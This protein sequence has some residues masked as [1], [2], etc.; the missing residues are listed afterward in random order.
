MKRPVFLEGVLVAGIASAAGAILFSIAGTLVAGGMA[1]RL[2]V[3]AVSLAYILYLL[4]R[5]QQRIGRI[6]CIAAWLVV[7]AG[8]WI[9]NPSLV[10]YIGAHIGLIWLCR[11]LY[12]YSSALPVLADLGLNALSVAAAGW[13]VIHSGSV[14]LSLWCFFLVQALFALIPTQVKRSSRCG[15]QLHSG[16]RNHDRF[17]HAHRAAEA[18]LRK[19][20]AIHSSREA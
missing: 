18:A 6:V 3:A 2:V 20:S 1:L 10:I 14:G 8:V 16:H 17:Q 5:S 7:A 19:L 9:A 11:S 15:D 4:R 12:F 13:A